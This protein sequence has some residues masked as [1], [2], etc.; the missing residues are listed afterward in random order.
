M[1]MATIEAQAAAWEAYRAAKVKADTSLDFRDGRA[2]A[3]AWNAFMALF[4]QEW[5]PT[6]VDLLLHTRKARS[7]G[8]VTR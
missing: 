6:P 1:T 5:P 3:L 4:V 8:T 7:S 2:A